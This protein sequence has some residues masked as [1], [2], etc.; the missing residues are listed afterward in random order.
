MPE[1]D[2]A[3]VTDTTLPDTEV[4]PVT[5]TTFPETLVVTTKPDARYKPD[6]KAG[7]PDTNATG[8]VSPDVTDMTFPETETAPV[9]DTNCP[10]ILASTDNPEARYKPEAR[11]CPEAKY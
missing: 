11:Y 10:D 7:A 2:T 4:A 1:T 9:T 3:P 6:N 5:D 8:I